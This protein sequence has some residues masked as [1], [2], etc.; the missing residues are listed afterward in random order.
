MYK[1]CYYKYA[2]LDYKCF[3]LTD[4]LLKY[5]ADIFMPHSVTHIAKIIYHDLQVSEKQNIIMIFV[6]D[7]LNNLLVIRLKLITYINCTAETMLFILI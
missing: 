1:M 6:Y 7:S 2:V 3:C 5:I 4:I